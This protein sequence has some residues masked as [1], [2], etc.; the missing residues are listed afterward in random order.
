[1]NPLKLPYRLLK[2]ILFGNHD[3]QYIRF[4]K[5]RQNQKIHSYLVHC[6]SPKLQI[7][8]QGNP[9]SGWLNTDILPKSNNVVYLDASK[10]FPIESNTFNY[11][12]SEHMIEHITF[13]EAEIMISECYRILKPGGKIRLAT[14]NVRSMVALFEEKLSSDQTEYINHMKKFFDPSLPDDPVFAINQMFYGFH[15]KFIHSKE[16]LTYLLRKNR[17][18]SI[19]FPQV[20]ESTDTN[21][22]SIEQHA[23]EI[24]DKFNRLETI[25]IE[26][27]K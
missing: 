27:S 11:I 2:R 22:K 6:S 7:G 23:K 26:A 18:K 9:I 17:F 21:L 19:S 4:H 15:H 16:S 13:A 8:A 5:K 20:M 12:F 3:K 1:M 25:V 14:P 24:G 10:P